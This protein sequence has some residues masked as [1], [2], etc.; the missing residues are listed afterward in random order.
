MR[1]SVCQQVRSRG[2]G[3]GAVAAVRLPV[4]RG[5]RGRELRRRV[6]GVP[7]AAARDA[8]GAAAPGSA[9]QAQAG[10][11]QRVQGVGHDIRQEQQQTGPEEAPVAEHM[12]HVGVRGRRAQRDAD[13]V[14]DGRGKRTPPPLSPCVRHE[15]TTPPPPVPTAVP[16]SP[17]TTTKT[18]DCSR[19]VLTNTNFCFLNCSQKNCTLHVL[20]GRYTP[21]SF[22]KHTHLG[23]F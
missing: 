16:R 22:G 4:L 3:T 19:L 6:A 12:T 8:R 15:R 9:D 11:E 20:K 17:P 21:T 1:R 5:E 7:L 14:K 23:S 2:R 18:F 13:A 10:R